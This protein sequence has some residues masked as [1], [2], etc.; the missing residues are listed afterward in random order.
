MKILYIGGF[1]LPDKNAAA[2]RVMSNAKLLK[3]M[4]FEVSFIG[5]SKDINDAPHN[6]HG[7]VSNPVPY[8]SDVR[9]WIKQIFTFVDTRTILKESPDYV[10]L[11]N[12]PSIASLRIIRACH[13]KGIKVIC[14]LTEWE[15]AYGYSPR[16]LVKKID[17]WLRMHYCIERMDGVIAISKFLYDY[18]KDKTNCIY[19]PPTVDLQDS[20][21][22]RNRELETHEKVQL[23][24]AGTGKGDGNKDRL[25][26]VI[27]SLL[28]KPN[29]ELTIIG[30]TKEEY[31]YSYG[32]EIPNDV[33]VYFKGR[34]SHIDAITAVQNSD[35]QVLIRPNNLKN[36]AGFP[37]KLV[38]SI[39]CCTPI[40]ATKTSNICDYIIDGEN[41][42]LVSDIRNLKDIMKRVETMSKGE[43]IEMKKACRK[44]QSFDYRIFKNEINK[45]FI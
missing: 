9:T 31:I 1:E 6:V 32:K 19:M 23:I 25:D 7:F 37:T 24:Y 8:P 36:N 12:F 28:G 38:E 15:L 30:M 27:D 10:V 5:I 43:I 2:H 21:W 20:K 44:M 11:Y 42:I 26:F 3:E 41:G 4:G 17:V 22:N 16:I 45:L 29:I 35:F 14:D 34:V 18:Y 13:K 33:K 40:I 39:C